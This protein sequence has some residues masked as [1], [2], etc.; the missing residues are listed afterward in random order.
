MMKTDLQIPELLSDTIKNIALIGKSNF[1]KS[2]GI[3]AIFMKGFIPL[4]PYLVR[5]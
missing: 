2:I 4:I 5:E 1:N 3:E